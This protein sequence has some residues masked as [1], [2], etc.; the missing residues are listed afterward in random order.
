MQEKSPQGIKDKA[1][2]RNPLHSR[3]IQLLKVKKTSTH[4][5]FLQRLDRWSITMLW[6]KVSNFMKIRA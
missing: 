3:I 6:A 5:D 4:S 1:E 2:A